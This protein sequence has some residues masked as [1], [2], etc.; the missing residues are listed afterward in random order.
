MLILA[1]IL[2][3]LGVVVATVPPV[4]NPLGWVLLIIGVVLLIVVLVP[5]GHADT[6]VVLAM[7]LPPGGLALS[8]GGA[9]PSDDQEPLVPL[10]T[11]PKREPVILA[12]IV[13]AVPVVCAFA[14][15]VLDA[16][17]ALDS[18][19]WIRTLLTGLGGVVG[20]LAAAWARAQVTPTAAPKLDADTLLVPLVESEHTGH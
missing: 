5:S 9:G 4:A 19:L 6:A 14:L 20:A 3:V 11:A 7:A 1:I 13:A 15:Q 12:F 16:A 18:A 10:A 2:I 8:H 17:G